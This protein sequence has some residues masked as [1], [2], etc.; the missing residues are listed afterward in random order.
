[1]TSQSKLCSQFTQAKRSIR[2]ILVRANQKNRILE[3]I[4]GLS[5]LY[6]CLHL[7]FFIN[8]ASLRI[9]SLRDCFI[10]PFSL[11]VANLKLFLDLK[12]RLANPFLV[13]NSFKLST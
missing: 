3:T 7:T 9:A 1:M 5:N 4:K 12:N 8:K 6:T 13:Q 11:M 2:A 10:Y